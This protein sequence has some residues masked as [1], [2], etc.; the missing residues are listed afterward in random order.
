[1]RI[2]KML[3]LL[4]TSVCCNRLYWQLKLILQSTLLFCDVSS[5]LYIRLKGKHST[6]KSY[7]QCSLNTVWT[8]TCI[9]DDILMILPAYCLSAAISYNHV[10]CVTPTP[11]L[12]STDNSR[13][14]VWTLCH[15]KSSSVLKIANKNMSDARICEVGSTLAPLNVFFFSK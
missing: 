14:V 2:S 1:M 12:L 9:R 11:V 10:V 8:P 5:S 13:N 3:S 6:L 7:Q 4:S 15:W